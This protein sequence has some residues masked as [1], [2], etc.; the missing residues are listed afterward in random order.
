MTMK[1]RLD[2]ALNNYTFK[3]EGADLNALIAYAYY[4]GRCSAAKEVC[5]EARAVF[6][7][8]KQRAENCRY[9]TMA[10]NVQGDINYIYHADYDGW[11]NMFNN[12]KLDDNIG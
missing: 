6:T 7:E 4:A 10:K 8:Q 12:D 11:I 3:A 5:D 9:H 1:E 2:K